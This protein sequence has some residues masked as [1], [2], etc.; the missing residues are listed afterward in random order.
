MEMHVQGQIRG[1][2]GSHAAGGK[3]R[4]QERAVGQLVAHSQLLAQVALRMGGGAVQSRV[5]A[6][7]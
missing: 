3:G 2:S 5:R 7:T 6:Q 4:K 1:P